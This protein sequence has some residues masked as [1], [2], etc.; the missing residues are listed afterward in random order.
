MPR[1][2]PPRQCRRLQKFNGA[3]TAWMLISTVLVLLMTIPG[4]ML[5]YSGMMRAKNALSIV[6]HTFAATAVVTLVWAGIAYSLAFTPGSPW[7]GA[8]SRAL[9]DG[10]LG[11]KVGAHPSAPTVP[12]SAFSC[13]SWPSPSSPSR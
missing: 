11:A 13:S 8:M 4:I 3:D 5:F 6:A 10:L 12:E 7:I 2:P 1:Q 9:S